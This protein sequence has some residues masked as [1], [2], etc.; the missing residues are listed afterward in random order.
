MV[1]VVK[2]QAAVAIM[3]DLHMLNLNLLDQPIPATPPPLSPSPGFR[4]EDWDQKKFD[5]THA[6]WMAV[7]KNQTPIIGI[8]GKQSNI[9]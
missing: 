7:Q 9:K 1:V 4:D 5:Q 3:H 6:D 2:G 8:P